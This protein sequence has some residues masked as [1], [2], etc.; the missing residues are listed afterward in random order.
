MC[1]PTC[2]HVQQAWAQKRPLLKDCGKGI[3][4]VGLHK[5]EPCFHYLIY[6]MNT[7]ICID[8]SLIKFLDP[9]V[10]TTGTLFNIHESSAPLL[11]LFQVFEIWWYLTNYKTWTTTAK[12]YTEGLWFWLMQCLVHQK[13]GRENGISQVN[14]MCPIVSIPLGIS[15][16]PLGKAFVL[17]GWMNGVLGHF[18]AL[19]RLNWA[20]D[21]LG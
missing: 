7:N 16:F 17:D 10:E 13:L 5:I 8:L 2:E 19:S 3:I 15:S 21:N 12:S 18:Y 1:K 20:G 11:S 4:V 14:C 9:V 6:H